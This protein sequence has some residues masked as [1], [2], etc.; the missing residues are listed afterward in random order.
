M[1]HQ[2]DNISNRIRELDNEI[3]KLKKKLSAM[4]WERDKYH[5]FSKKTPMQ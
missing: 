5:Q 1:R 4:I 2:T 3:D